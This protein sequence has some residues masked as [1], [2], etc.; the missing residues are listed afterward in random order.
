MLAPSFS[1]E[2]PAVLQNLDYDK[3]E[4]YYI[5]TTDGRTMHHL[6]TSSVYAYPDITGNPVGSRYGI[7]LDFNNPDLAGRIYYGLIHYSDSKF[8]H[9]VYRSYPAEIAQYGPFPEQVR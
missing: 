9:P 5:S 6:K 7:I 2:I 3:K 8:P 1:Q 4:G